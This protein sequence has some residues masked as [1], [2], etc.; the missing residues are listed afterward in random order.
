MAA[1]SGYSMSYFKKLF[2]DFYGVAPG[3][4]LTMLRINKAKAL[5]ESRL[6]SLSEI[7]DECGFS[8]ESYFSHAFKRVVGCPPKKY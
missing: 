8:S 5:L 1:A 2:K 6:F 3:E 7:A 4:Y